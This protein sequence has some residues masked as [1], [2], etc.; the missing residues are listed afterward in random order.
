MASDNIFDQVE[1][2]IAS[3]ER[4][5][6][7]ESVDA[8]LKLISKLPGAAPLVW[9]VRYESEKQRAENSELMLTTM[10]Q[11]LKRI[12]FAFEE[13]RKTSASRDGVK[14]LI[15]DGMRKAEDLRD[16]MRVERIGKILAHAISLGPT[17]NFD[18]AEEMMR[19][20]R[21]LSDHDVLALR[22]L[23]E[24]QFPA[25]DKTGWTLDVDAVNKIWRENPPKIP[26][27][28]LPGELDSVLLKLQGLGLATSVERRETQVGPNLRVFAL[29]PKGAD[30]IHYIR[31][32]VT[33]TLIGSA[34]ASG[35]AS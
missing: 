12:A 4:Q 18:K 24:S 2:L 17:S 32:A 31:G 3:D 1:A 23:Y 5:Q 10:W 21:D 29:L 13:M 11:E 19:V 30:F 35:S 22:H 28:P 25:N 9:A 20:A 7:P 6:L 27:T 34:G 16:R 26:G 15:V 14:R 8:L 33:E